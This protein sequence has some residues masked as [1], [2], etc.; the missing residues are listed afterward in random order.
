MLNPIPM[1]KSLKLSSMGGPIAIAH[2]AG[3]VWQEG[4]VPILFLMATLSLGLGFFNLLPLP[5]L[6]GG[7]IVM[8]MLEWVIGRPL[9]TRVRQWFSIAAFTLLI[10]LLLVLS[11]GDLIKIPAI[12]RWLQVP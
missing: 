5:V 7:M 6:D 11:W 8:E 4:L 1:L 2:Q 3:N 10:G 12:A 9:S